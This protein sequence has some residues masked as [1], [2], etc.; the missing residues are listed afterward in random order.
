MDKRTLLTHVTD[1]GAVYV[2]DNHAFRQASIVVRIDASIGNENPEAIADEIV[3]RWNTYP[4]LLAALKEALRTLVTPQGFPD[5]K[6]RTQEQQAAY[7]QA[8]A[9]IT[10]ATNTH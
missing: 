2:S 4:E 3:K 5:A 7:D 9:A 1:G 6:H 10:N 8:R